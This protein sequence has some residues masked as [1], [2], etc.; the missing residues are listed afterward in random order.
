[1]E[2]Y[3]NNSSLLI[4]IF[5][6]LCFIFSFYDKLKANYSI[7]KRLFYLEGTENNKFGELK[8]IKDLINLHEGKDI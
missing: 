6:V 5:K 2:F 1:M 7:I 4:T 3:A 8:K